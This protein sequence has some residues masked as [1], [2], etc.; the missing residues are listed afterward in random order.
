MKVDMSPE[1]VSMRLDTMGELW[2]LSVALMDSTITPA[3]SAVDHGASATDEQM[4]R[5][6]AGFQASPILHE[7]LGN[8]IDL[9]ARAKFETKKDDRK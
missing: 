1:A 9:Q 7:Y 2:E 4:D 3:A 8:L 6:R 5:P